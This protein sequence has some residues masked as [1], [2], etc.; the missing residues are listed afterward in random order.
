M[1][2]IKQEIYKDN[3][4]DLHLEFLEAINILKLKE[5][6]T[7]EDLRR[8]IMQLIK[9]IVHAIR[10]YKKDN[11]IKVIKQAKEYI[12]ENYNTNITL[13]EIAYEVEMSKN[14]FSYLFKRETGIGMWDYLIRTRIEKAKELLQESNVRIYEVAYK[15]GYENSSYFNKMFKRY[16]GMTPREYKINK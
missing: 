4:D 8:Y 12:K 11:N 1:I 15:V 5:Y 10:E 13:D 3:I 6:K 2:L 16:T 9:N 7:Y 14:Y